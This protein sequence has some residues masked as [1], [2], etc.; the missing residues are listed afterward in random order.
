MR[1]GRW[2]R[3]GAAKSSVL[4][5]HSVHSRAGVSGECS[6]CEAHAPASLKGMTDG[7]RM[8]GNCPNQNSSELPGPT[9]PAIGMGSQACV[10]ARG[11]G[12]CCF[13]GRWGSVRVCPGPG[14]AIRPWRQRPHPLLLRGGTAQ[15]E[16]GRLPPGPHSFGVEKPA[17][18]GE[19]F[20]QM[21]VPRWQLTLIT[22]EHL[23]GTSCPFLPPILRLLWP[24]FSSKLNSSISVSEP[25]RSF[26]S[27]RTVPFAFHE[28]S[29][30]NWPVA[31]GGCRCSADSLGTDLDAKGGRRGRGEGKG[32]GRKSMERPG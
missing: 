11:P 6:G 26:P 32:R 31:R 9:L 8:S 2:V 30:H 19:S 15:D 14:G 18:F 28:G 25:S 20:L 7:S 10:D 29:Q 24:S 23:V 17:W 4:R 5:P 3:R 16:C 13:R 22:C 1:L 27:T 12:K 21:P